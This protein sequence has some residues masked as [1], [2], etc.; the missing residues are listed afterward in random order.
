MITAVILA[1]ILSALPGLSHAKTLTIGLIPEQN[2]FKQVERFTPL[3]E[4]LEKKTGIKVKFTML[5]RYG[6]IIDRFTSERMD[7]A[8]FGSFT[9]ALA[10][11]KLGV[12]P[13]AR[14]AN[15]DGPATYRGYIFVRKD[16]GI[17][18]VDN[19]RGRTIVFVERATT[20]GYV[21]PIAFLRQHGIADINSYFRRHYFAGSHDAAIYAVLD[22]KA[23]VG[24]A[25]H[26]IFDMLARSDPRIT[27]DLRIVATSP[28]VPSNGLCV[29]KDMDAETKRLL[30]EALLGMNEDPEGRAVLAQFS[31]LRFV[32]AAREDYKPVFDIAEKAGIDMKNY[33][34]LNK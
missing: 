28:A 18:T 11:Q 17:K 2:V 14:P 12:E 16:S 20:A 1:L 8:F 9:G 33:Q 19:M 15:L 10:I 26:S 24:C 5:S 27:R 29:R 23:D 4:Y 7:G 31:A 32:P 30:R 21:Y 6:N 3:G 22:R 13:L 25:K 34:Y